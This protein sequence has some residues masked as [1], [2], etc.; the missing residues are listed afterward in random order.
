MEKE[1]NKDAKEIRKSGIRIAGNIPWGTHLCQFYETKEDMINIL[2]PYFKAGLENNEFCIWITSMALNEEEA[3]NAMRNAMP[4]F[5]K[6]LESGKMEIIPHDRWY[7][8]SGSFNAQTVIGLWVGRLDK[9][10]AEGYIGMR[11]S[12]DTSW[13]EKKDWMNFK[14]YEQEGNNNF[15]KY[16]IIALCTYPVNKCRVSEIIDVACNHQH[17]LIKREGRWELMESSVRRNAEDELKALKDIMKL[18]KKNSLTNNAKLVLYSL[19]KYPLFNDRQFSM[20]LNVK[21]STITAIR[22]KLKKEGF[23]STCNIPEFA[24]IGC[25]LMS[26]FNGEIPVEDGN[27]N[28]IFSI[29]EMVYAVRT[30]KHYLSITL[31]KDAAE[32]RRIADNISAAYK[33]NVETHI[34]SFPLAKIKTTRLFDY[35]SLLKSLFSLKIENDSK[36][37]AA[38]PKIPV[39]K[40]LSYNEKII[41][42]SLVKYPDLTNSEISARTGLSKPTIG[43]I[44]EKLIN[45]GFIKVVNIPD[46]RK[47]GCKLLVYSN[48]TCL[49]QNKLKQE[50]HFLIFATNDKKQTCSIFVFEDYSKYDLKRQIFGQM[51]QLFPVQNIK[52]QKM[53]FGPFVKKIFGLKTDF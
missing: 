40:E 20:K 45:E 27:S 33:R 53:D 31:S 13:I 25:K 3:K 22:N 12:G 5:D 24:L 18:T 14:D 6:C 39:K 9:A 29:P 41:L 23:Y 43:K 51:T 52:Y 4:D 34:T 30:D 15:F 42:Y 2:A 38:N 19:V 35:S 17:T 36:E 16:P 48:G 28:E 7:L 37:E 1:K 21:R 26:I 46:I 11:M 49:M 50:E 32:M 8:Q 44:K 47:L 10:L